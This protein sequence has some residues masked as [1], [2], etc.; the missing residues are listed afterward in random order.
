[1]PNQRKKILGICDCGDIAKYGINRLG[2]SALGVTLPRSKPTWTKV[3]FDCVRLIELENREVQSLD[4][5]ESVP[6]KA[7]RWSYAGQ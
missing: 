5:K 6:G 3:C 2:E 4:M 1:M 7:F